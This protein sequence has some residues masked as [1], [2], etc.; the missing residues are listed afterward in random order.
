MGSSPRGYTVL[1]MG[2]FV[3]L[4]T[5]GGIGTIRLTR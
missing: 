5:D 3:N 4:E 2:E 1:R